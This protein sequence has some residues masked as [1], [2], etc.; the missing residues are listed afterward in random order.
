MKLNKQTDYALRILIYS[1]LEPG[2]RLLSIQEV[3]DVYDFSR[4]HVMK[5]V[6][7]LGQLGYL[8]TVRG[9]GGGFHIGREAIHINL[10]QLVRDME[11]SLALVDCAQPACQLSP[12]CQLKHVLAEAMEAF[13]GVLDKYTLDDM[14]HNRKELVQLLAIA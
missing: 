2:E 5:I 6:Q 1:A 4:N 12:G 11:N 3:T 14:I 10:G 7:K 9:K 8:K 13:M